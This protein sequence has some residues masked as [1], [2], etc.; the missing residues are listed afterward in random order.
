M[1]EIK[2][3]NINREYILKRTAEIADLE[4]DIEELESILNNR[5]NEFPLIL[6]ML[7]RCRTGN[8]AGI[9]HPADRKPG[10]TLFIDLADACL[11]QHF[12]PIF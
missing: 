9:R 8:T 12:S 7:V 1:A 6:E 3:R 11:N 2:L 4:R 5:R 10:D